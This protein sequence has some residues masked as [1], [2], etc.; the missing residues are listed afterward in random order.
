MDH[1]TRPWAGRALASIALAVWWQEPPH[2]TCCTL[3]YSVLVLERG[4][5]LAASRQRPRPG[6]GTTF[7]R[8]QACRPV[9]TGYRFD[10]RVHKDDASKMRLFLRLQ[11]LAVRIACLSGASECVDDFWDGPP[12]DY[13]DVIAEF[14]R[15]TIAEVEQRRAQDDAIDREEGSPSSEDSS[16][17]LHTHSCSSCS[18][19]TIVVVPS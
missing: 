9:E 2:L 10:L 12:D 1:G 13:D 4:H 7:A 17:L 11:W 15:M 19:V 14:M 5:V 8:L 3:C 16:S 6:E 18:E